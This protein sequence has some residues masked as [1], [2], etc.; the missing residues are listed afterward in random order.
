MSDPG[1]SATPGWYPDPWGA[2][3]QR[4]WDGREWTG[5][6]I[7][8]FSY[9]GVSAERLTIP[10]SQFGAD[11]KTAASACLSSPRLLFVTLAVQV[12]PSALVALGQSATALGVLGLLIDLLTIGFFGTQRVWLLRI[13]HGESLS[14]GEIYKLTRDYF[15]RFF[16]LGV[17][18]FLPAGLIIGVAAVSRN[19]AATLVIAGVTG[20]VL[21]V[22][23]TFVVPDL[24]FVA[25]SPKHAWETGRALL[26]Q[27]WPQSR[28]YVLTPGIAL[29]TVANAL[30]GLNHGAAVVIPESALSALLSLIFRGTILAYYIRLRPSTNLPATRP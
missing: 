20:F 26:R 17:R 14:A 25:A 24:T 18:V 28:W 22:L 5:A 16:G 1:D 15:G 12:V 29:I 21:D 11:F 4:W 23:L 27:S 30:S 8:G 19:T 13:Y 10:E 6:I 9:P 7:G 3:P 2:A